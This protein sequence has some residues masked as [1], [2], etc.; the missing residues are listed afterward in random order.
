MT[1]PPFFKVCGAAAVL[2]I[3]A[4][5]PLAQAAKGK[6][7]G[8][9]VV[10]TSDQVVPPVSTGAK[11]KGTITV[12]Q[13]GAMSGTVTTPG[14]KGFQAQIHIGAKGE[15]GPMALPLM[16]TETGDWVV[17]KDAKLSADQLK[18]YTAGQMYVE[19]QTPKFMKGEVRGQLKP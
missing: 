18:R 15:N 12:D 7:M 1:K 16:P 6:L 10:L 14:I 9:E 13:D 5:S 3:A 11:G 17:P 19:V 8:G 4:L 2:A